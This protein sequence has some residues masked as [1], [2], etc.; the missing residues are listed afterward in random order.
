MK[1]TEP[2][3][4]DIVT[5]NTKES[6]ALWISLF[7]FFISLST[8][9]YTMWYNYTTNI[10]NRTDFYSINA[11]YLKLELEDCFLNSGIE[12]QFTKKDT[13]TLLLRFK[14]SNNGNQRCEILGYFILNPKKYNPKKEA[15]IN[16]LPDSALK[17]KAN[18][19]IRIKQTELLP[20]DVQSSYLLSAG[21][22]I[23]SEPLYPF[24]FV[25]IYKNAI[26]GYYAMQYDYDGSID[27]N[28]INEGQLYKTIQVKPVLR[29]S[30]FRA[31]SENESM[32]LIDKIKNMKGGGASIDFRYE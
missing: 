22:N 2:L 4:V 12:K 16:T 19:L 20:N 32:I 30:F 7:S 29:N 17:S 28:L 8:F 1:Q 25:I 6:W 18:D 27:L 3:K 23:V 21:T 9:G 26:G 5:R 13:L 15:F 24:T 31:F 14:I 10:Q 11:S